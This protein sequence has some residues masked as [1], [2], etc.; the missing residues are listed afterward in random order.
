MYCFLEKKC[1][2]RFRLGTP[3]DHMNFG[4]NLAPRPAEGGICEG[5]SAIALSFAKRHC[6]ARSVL[7]LRVSPKASEYIELYKNFIWA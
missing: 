5:A 7:L 2:A 3:S 4:I 1:I 6:L